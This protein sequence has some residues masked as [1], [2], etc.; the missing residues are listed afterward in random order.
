MPPAAPSFL[1]MYRTNENSTL[2][3]VLEPRRL[4]AGAS[5][6]SG[7]LTVNGTN[8]RDII[9]V[10][11]ERKNAKNLDVKINGSVKAFTLA[12]VKSMLIH[13]GDGNDSIS[14]D[15]GFGSINAPVTVFA[16]SGND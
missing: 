10:F 1:R 8:S 9:T 12:S 16:G 7:L 14:V 3:D 6:S 5:L 13:G 2:I 15:E 4:L 11:V